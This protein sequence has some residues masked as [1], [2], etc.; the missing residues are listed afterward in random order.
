MSFGEDGALR[1]FE[2]SV[3]L[4]RVREFVQLKGAVADGTLSVSVLSRGD[5]YSGEEV[6][7]REVCRREIRLP[8]GA[9]VADAF[10]PQPRLRNLSKGQTWKHQ[11]YRPFPPTGPIEIVQAK[12]ER[13]VTY[14]WN[15]EPV[16]TFLV[17]YRGEAGSGITATRE[18]IGKMWVRKDGTVLRQEVRVA[19]LR[20]VFTRLSDRASVEKA[21]LIG[22]LWESDGP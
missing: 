16:Q 18:P 3:H 6:E 20:F 14:R 2:S 22:D 4:G 17:V 21:S 7:P 12:V 19:N 1:S 13:G 10:S 8:R 15:G 9:L 5:L 11:V